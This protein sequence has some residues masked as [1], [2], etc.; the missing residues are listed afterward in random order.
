MLISLGY[1]EWE[2]I[3]DFHGA[4]MFW[5]HYGPERS[6]EIIRGAKFEILFD[7]FVLSGEEKHYWI[8]AK[9]RSS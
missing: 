6:L 7:K 1:S 8:L 5:S 2:G 4:E 9:N 3:E